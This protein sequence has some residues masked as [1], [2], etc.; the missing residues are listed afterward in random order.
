[1]TG[2]QEKETGK[3][4]LLDGEK[5]VDDVVMFHHIKSETCIINEKIV[6]GL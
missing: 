4:F 5:I 3:V 2:Q 1:L 6:C